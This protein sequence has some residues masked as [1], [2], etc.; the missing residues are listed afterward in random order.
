[1]ANK[2][3]FDEK[4]KRFNEVKKDL[5]KIIGNMAVNHFKDSFRAGGF[6][7]ATFKPWP[8]RKP[9]AKRNSGRAILVD[10][11]HLKSSVNLKESTFSKI[12]ISSEGLSY[13]D[14]HNR[15]LRAG[16]GKGFTM[17]KRKFMGNSAKLQKQMLDKIN[18]KIKGVF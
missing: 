15:G 5:P 12:R 7:D 2:F 9:G 11:G 6:T 14:V 13:A 4:I 16:R 1:M 17:P 8:K 10:T 18:S 3:K